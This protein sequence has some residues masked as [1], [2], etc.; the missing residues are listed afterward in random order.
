MCIRDRSCMTDGKEY[1]LLPFHTF[2]ILQNSIG[3]NHMLSLNWEEPNVQ[4]INHSWNVKIQT[5]MLTWWNVVSQ[6]QE[7]P[8]L[9]DKVSHFSMLHDIN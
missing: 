1:E 9:P 4:Y 7:N 5:V 8:I 6:Q 3:Q 2:L